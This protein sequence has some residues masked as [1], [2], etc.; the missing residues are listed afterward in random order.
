[1]AGVLGDLRL[2]VKVRTNHM[3]RVLNG[4]T[5]PT[6]LGTSKLMVTNHTKAKVTPETCLLLDILREE[7]GADVHVPSIDLSEHVERPYQQLQ[8]APRTARVSALAGANPPDDWIPPPPPAVVCE[9][10]LGFGEVTNASGVK[11]ALAIFGWLVFQL[12]GKVTV[13]FEGVYDGQ[14]VGSGAD[15]S[16]IWRT[17]NRRERN[18]TTER[19][20]RAT[21]KRPARAANF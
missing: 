4:L 21:V 7:M 19:V 8:F 1:M 9:F 16:G 14:E 11:K 15:S 10:D 5:H 2:T 12:E 20:T 13:P 3:S 18:A 17:A 6:E